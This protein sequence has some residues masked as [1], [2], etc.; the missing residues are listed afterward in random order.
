M[1]MPDDDS[2][3]LSWQQ[4]TPANKTTGNHRQES[5][6]EF[7]SY[8]F[9]KHTRLMINLNGNVIAMILSS[10]QCDVNGFQT[11]LIN[12]INV[13]VGIGIARPGVFL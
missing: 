11:F 13:F 8:V 3:P 6:E 5:L 12:T 1:S 2:S 4:E 9:V 10:Q 7:C